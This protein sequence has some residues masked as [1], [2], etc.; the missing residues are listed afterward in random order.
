MSTQS[1]KSSQKLKQL[2][3]RAAKLESE[4]KFLKQEM[5]EKQGDYHKARLQLKDIKYEIGQL[6]DKDIVVSE[7]AML[8]YLERAM[9][10]DLDD[11][12]QAILTEE[13]KAYVGKLG[14]GKYPIG[15]GLRVVVKDNVVVSVVD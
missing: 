4:I 1:I 2:Q 9:G 12:K 5:E 3:S 7:H 13:I 15:N 11:I 10:L 14:N 6:K 8:R